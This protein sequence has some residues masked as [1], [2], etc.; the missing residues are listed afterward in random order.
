MIG[1]YFEPFWSLC[2]KEEAAQSLTVHP[3]TKI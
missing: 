1:L 3:T 2:W